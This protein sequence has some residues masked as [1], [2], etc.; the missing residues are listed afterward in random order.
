MLGRR[1]GAKSTSARASRAYAGKGRL[2]D[3]HAVRVSRRAGGRARVCSLHQSRFS[4]GRALD[5]AGGMGREA[6]REALCVGPLVGDRFG[7]ALDDV[8]ALRDMKRET[9]C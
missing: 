8:P 9:S 2:L 6:G 3:V 4:G 1:K 5:Y 7:C